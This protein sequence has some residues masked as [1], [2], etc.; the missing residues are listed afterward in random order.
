MSMAGDGPRLVVDCTGDEVRTKQS[1]KAETDINNIVARYRRTGFVEYVNERS[2]VYADVSDVNDYR[3]AVARVQA[4]EEF[5]AGLPSK[6]R[7]EFANDPA[8]FLDFMTDESPEAKARA[9]KLGLVARVVEPL[10]AKVA[11]RVDEVP[12]PGVQGRGADGRFIAPGGP[13]GGA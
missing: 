6:V 1:M 3:E 12:G 4:A 9:E 13:A 11:E 7:T 5:F 10:V 8:G 2:P